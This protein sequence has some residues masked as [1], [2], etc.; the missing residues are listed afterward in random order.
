MGGISLVILEFNYGTNLDAAGGDVR[1]KIDLVRNFLPDDANSPVTI[2]MDPSM[3]PIMMLAL[4]GSRTPEALLQKT[5]LRLVLNR[6]TVLPLQTF[7]VVV[8]NQLTLIFPATVLK[9][10]DLQ[11]PMFLR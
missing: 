11:F 6:L 1:D 3:M 10:M 4:R 5:Q 2:K 9:L 8:K 7:P